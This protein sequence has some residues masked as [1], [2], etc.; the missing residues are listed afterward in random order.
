MDPTRITR[1]AFVAAGTAPLALSAAGCLAPTLKMG[2]PHA[3][4]IPD[5]SNGTLVNDI[6][7][8][9]NATRV[10]EIVRPQTLEAT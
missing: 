10:A 2:L 8:K 1:R 6:H 5:I 7:S 4:G 9:L 3:S